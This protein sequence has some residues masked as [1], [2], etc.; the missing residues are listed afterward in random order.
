MSISAL[1]LSRTPNSLATSRTTQA[2]AIAQGRLSRLQT[3]LGTGQKYLLPSESPTAATQAIAL[4]KVDERAAAFQTSLQTN[5]GFLAV[6]DQSLG[7]ISDALARA[8]GLLQAG[9]GDQVTADEREALAQEVAALTKSIIQAANTTYNGRA[10]FA[11]SATGGVPFEQIGDGLVRYNG[12]SQTLSGLADF[13]TLVASG[14]DG[15]NGLQATTTTAT[16]ADLNPAVTLGTRLDQLHRGQG[17]DLGSL[18][19]IVSGISKTI[20]LSGAETLDDVKLRI[21][22]AFSTELITVDVD[23]NAAANGL[24]ITTAGTVEVRDLQSGNTAL[25]LGLRGGP[26]AN[27]QGSDV[28]PVLSLLTPLSALNGGV[29]IDVTAGAG[30]RIENGGMVRTVDLAGAVTVQDVL[31]RILETDPN[32]IAE[33][34]PDG[35]GLSVTSRLSGANFSIGEVSG[36][37]NATELGLRTFTA[38]TLLADLNLGVGV[39]GV[40][41]QPLTIIRR[42]GSQVTVD[43]SGA[44]TVQD[45]LNKINDVE[46]GVLVAALNTVGNGISLQDNSLFAGPLTVVENDWSVKLGLN[47]TGPTGVLAGRDVNPQQ[48]AGAFNVLSRLE[49]ALRDRDL[50]TLERLAEELDAAYGHVTIVRGDLGN[51]QRQL[52]SIDNLLADRHVE[53][54]D[55]LSK[56]QDVDLSVTITEF[57]A[58]QQSMQAYLKIASETL[59]VSI[60]QYL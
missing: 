46:P 15:V 31:N 58:Q 24:Q 26:T 60:L 36:H 48:A 18:Q 56:L 53:I 8:R 30:L 54:K 44:A 4:Q 17:V 37:A 49:Q 16:A 42:D 10:I 6:A 11:G 12:N 41:A 57:L 34:S 38:N 39:P 20:D 25:Q 47:G 43:L 51:D 28:D 13:N 59:Q 23:I 35:R 32:V 1:S 19:V 14:I 52:E 33:I 7:T 29:G 5:L 27:L 21:E 3:Q 2:I 50:P 9:I 22:D 45:V 40:D 55:R